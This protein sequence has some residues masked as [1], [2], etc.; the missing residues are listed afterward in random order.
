MIQSLQSQWI[1]AKSSLQVGAICRH[2]L[3][4]RKIVTWHGNLD[5]ATTRL[6]SLMS[7]HN[8]PMSVI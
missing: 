3:D 7:G 6:C 8:T 4:L 5:R 1:S 2:L